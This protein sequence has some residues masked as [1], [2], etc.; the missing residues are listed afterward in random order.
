VGWLIY[1]EGLDLFT[2]LGAT[3]ILSG[4]LL[5]LKPDKHLPARVGA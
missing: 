3:L 4:N 2:V 5:N 1:S